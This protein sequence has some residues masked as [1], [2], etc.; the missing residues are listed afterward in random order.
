[1]TVIQFNYHLSAV[2]ANLATLEPSKGL[3]HLGFRSNQPK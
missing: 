3:I 2:S 1:V